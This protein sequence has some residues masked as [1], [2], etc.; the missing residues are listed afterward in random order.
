MKHVVSLET[1]DLVVDRNSAADLRC[2]V[3]V[4][5]L[6][7]PVVSCQNGHLFCESCVKREKL[8][9]V[10]RVLI[11]REGGLARALFV[12]RQMANTMVY[13]VYRFPET[14]DAKQEE[15]LPDP[16]GCQ[17]QL[18]LSSREEHHAVCPLRFVN[19]PYC[20]HRCRLNKLDA[21]KEV[22]IYRLVKCP[23][24]MEEKRGPAA[25]EGHLFNCPEKPIKCNQCGK[26]GILHKN[27][28]LHMR[29]TCSE[30]V[31]SCPFK[32]YGC[33]A[34]GNLLL[35]FVFFLAADVFLFGS[36]ERK[37]NGGAH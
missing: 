6:R 4:S 35:L 20:K 3:C 34:D 24:C 18:R 29:E 13:C 17:E 16:E 33:K 5:F 37:R 10:C 2:S 25:L 27:F 31:V 7:L 28:T 21:H 23:H 36:D 22:C 12:E 15:W 14:P 9:P 19:C 30:R 1:L 32:E 8:C 11:A 26:E